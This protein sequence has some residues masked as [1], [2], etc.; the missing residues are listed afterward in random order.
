MD[1]NLPLLL[2]RS[3]LGP[4]SPP[5]LGIEKSSGHHGIP[6]PWNNGW[7]EAQAGAEQCH[8]PK[9]VLMRARWRQLSLPSC[10]GQVNCVVMRGLNEDE[11]LDFVVLTEGLPLDVRFI[12]YMPFDGE[13]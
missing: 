4:N 9:V 6:Q 7:P 2:A 10:L 11:L 13:W 3:H 1:V 5:S 8:T 12:E